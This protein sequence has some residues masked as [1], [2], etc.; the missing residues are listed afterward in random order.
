MEK[1]YIA[2]TALAGLLAVIL[3]ILLIRRRKPKKERQASVRRLVKNAT[4]MSPDK[5]FTLRNTCFGTKTLG[6]SYNFAGVYIIYNKN[7][8]KY[9]V[10]QAKHIFSRVNNHLTG[11]GNGDVYADFV[12]GD[13]FTVRL[14]EL[15]GS[16]FKT[17]NQLERCV[18]SYFDAYEKGYNK[19][20]GNKG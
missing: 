20:K 1:D 13:K 18:I 7:T 12:Y 14:I 10:G 2:L 8:K 19:T 3:L 4:E 9:Y 15:Q 17:L 6:S 16:G 11:K 5:F